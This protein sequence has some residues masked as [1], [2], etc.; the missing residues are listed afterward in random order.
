[1]GGGPSKYVEHQERF[2]RDNYQKYK[3]ELGSNY[4][5][6]QVQGK[7]RQLYANSDTSRENRN[8]YI[9]DH[10][11]VEVSTKNKSRK[12]GKITNFGIIF[13]QSAQSLSELNHVKL[14]ETT[15]WVKGHEVEYAGYHHWA[16]EFG[17]IAA[18]RGFSVSPISDPSQSPSSTLYGEGCPG[19]AILVLGLT[20]APSAQSVPSVPFVDSKG[21]N[22]FLNS[23]I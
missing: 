10:K 18:S 19:D 15:K 14:E 4:S 13:L 23:F 11:W 21:V 20:C 12:E 8:S 3:N 1:M 9:L 2:V 17:D 5:S 16:H 7:L 6:L 22:F